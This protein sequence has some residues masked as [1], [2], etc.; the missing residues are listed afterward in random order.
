MRSSLACALLSLGAWASLPSPSALAQQHLLGG[1]VWSTLTRAVVRLKA[2]Q[3]ASS[4]TSR[5]SNGFLVRQGNRFRI[6]TTLH[7]VVGCARIEAQRHV[8][9]PVGQAGVSEERRVRLRRASPATDLAI[10]DAPSW[11]GRQALAIAPGGILDQSYFAVGFFDESLAITSEELTPKNTTALTLY[12]LLPPEV[13][14]ELLHAGVAFLSMDTYPFGGNLTPGS[15]GAPIVDARGKVIGVAQGG[16]EGGDTGKSWGIPAAAVRDLLA[17]DGS[18]HTGQVRGTAAAHKLLF[19]TA[20]PEEIEARLWRA[21]SL[22]VHYDRLGS[23]DARRHAL[24]LSGSRTL[25]LAR[26]GSSGYR[27]DLRID[28]EVAYGNQEREWHGPDGALLEQDHAHTF[29]VGGGVALGVRLWQLSDVAARADVGAIGGIVVA[30]QPTDQSE[31]RVLWYAA[32]PLR[33]RMTWM[34]S[35]GF[36]LG[37]EL[38]GGPALFPS[39]EWTYTTLGAAPRDEGHRWMPWFRIGLYHEW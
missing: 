21:W 2:K 12:Q 8:A 5:Q 4:P 11:S 33:V 7:S 26:L 35:P 39:F 16:L 31:S 29:S 25:R 24:G 22:G 13:G 20:L 14:E 34:Q 30:E 6:V 36:G 27:L 15:S 37:V 19:S 23:G 32:F 18:A 9:S 1:E 3:C 38:A 28:G 17:Q 10:L